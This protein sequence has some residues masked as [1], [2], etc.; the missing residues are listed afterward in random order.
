MS[1]DVQRTE[2][3]TGAGDVVMTIM[4]NLRRGKFSER[5]K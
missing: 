4:A 2:S 1:Q 5:H 3:R